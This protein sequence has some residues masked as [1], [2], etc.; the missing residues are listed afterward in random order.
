MTRSCCVRPAVLAG[1]LVAFLAA[2]LGA[3]EP[4]KVVTI[5]GITEYRLDNGLRVLLYPD[6]S[7][8]NVTV[9][10]TVLVGSRHEGY[11]ETGMAHL[12][13]HMVF[14]G[15]PTHPDVPKALRD[16]GARFNGTTWVDRTNY[17]ETLPGTD[18]NLDFA[19]RLEADRLVNSFVKREDLVS[20]M[21]VVRNEFE[22][23][24]N[25]PQRVLNQRMMAVAFE[26]HNYGK[27]TI[28]NRSD[29]ERV[30][31][32]RLQ[33][34]YKKYY[35]PDNAVLVVAGKFDEPRALAM[36]NKHFGALKK[37]ER[38]LETTY[39]E[40]P[41]QDGE[42]TVVLRRV[43]KVALAG[44]LY[45]V[46]AGS[47]EDFPAVEVLAAMLT[48]EP[49]GRLYKAL[50]V[51]KKASSVSADA[52]GWHD[53]GVLDVMAEVSEGTDPREVVDL[54]TNELEKLAA[55][56]APAEEVARART[57]LLK[58]RELSM[59]DSNRVGVVLSDWA[60]K[61]DWRLFFLHRDRLEKVTPEDVT[62]VAG[63]YLQRSNRTVGLYVPSTEVARTPVPPPPDVAALLKDYKGGATIAA[64]ESFEPTPENVERRVQRAELTGGVKMALL[65]KNSRGESVVMLLTLRY[66]N[67]ESLKGA[68][69][70]A[71]FL[72]PMM[73]RGTKKHSR[74]EFEDELDRLK[75]RISSGG[76]GG[77]R[78]GGGGGGGLGE[79]TFAVECRRDT[80]PAVVKLLGEALRE[81]AFPTEDF[82]VMRRQARDRLS[83]SLTDPQTIARRALQRKLSPYPADDVRYVPTDE[84]SLARLDKVTL[85]DVRKLYA[86]QVGATAG[87]VVVVGDFD[88]AE[89][90]K[91]IGD[92]LKDWKPGTPYRRVERQAKADVKGETIVI[93]TPDKANAVYAAAVPLALK[94][95]D[96]DYA[97]LVLGNFV[98]GGG[99][100][101]SR[102]GNRVRQKE[103]LSYGVG[104]TFSAD[105]LDPS[106]QFGMRAICNP[107]YM[108]KVEAAIADELAR[109]RK[110]GIGETEL[111]EAKKAYLEALKVGRSSDTALA[112]MLQEGL[113]AG[114]TFA[115]QAE[116]EKRVAGLTAAQVNE[117]F[118]KH[119][120][121]ERL[122][123]VQAGDFKKKGAQK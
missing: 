11:G 108:G 84:E 6:L 54:L 98:F 45:H 12:L 101:S 56:K 13:E 72:G 20:E 94:D 111:G 44:A 40:E 119:V 64:G 35:Q 74:Q 49:T 105:A 36:V 102:L 78:G 97:A 77:P 48:R 63:R 42:R 66:G 85:A 52:A 68:N 18:E 17:F 82:D 75:A 115:Y 1:L 92:L 79:L 65:P 60:A 69:A 55:E 58:A 70:A 90:P 109:M 116:L 113:Q 110:E 103:G 106:G 41:P 50:V 62:R 57:R 24:E 114:R 117:A 26:W 123:I 4:R 120:T 31:I 28:G 47:H 61:G 38:K 96:P 91:L 9:N 46:P 93:E 15:T 8:P 99:S 122:V 43:G 30:P 95:T 118:R 112:A 51:P 104:S 107:A 27:S 21:T 25:S 16:R 14:K 32:E 76:M 59:K 71:M 73:L 23:G 29:I 19:L 86:E 5:E 7:T 67:P 87:E 80:L 100:L 39:T 33:A 3:A 37:P 121:P 89:T 22:S 2:P 88:P 34:F 53:P 83:S 81:P 10:L